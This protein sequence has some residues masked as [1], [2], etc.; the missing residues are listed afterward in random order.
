[1]F[2]FVNRI[3]N[4]TAQLTDNKQYKFKQYIWNYNC[5]CVQM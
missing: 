5:M 3:I 4:N 1:M 2:T